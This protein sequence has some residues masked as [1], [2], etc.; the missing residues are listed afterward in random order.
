MDVC[1]TCCVCG[2][3]RPASGSNGSRR[4]WWQFCYW[5]SLRQSM[6]V[7]SF[8]QAAPTAINFCPSIEGQQATHIFYKAISSLVVASKSVQLEHAP[9]PPTTRTFTRSLR[10]SPAA[11]QIDFVHFG[12]IADN[13][14]TGENEPRTHLV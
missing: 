1:I 9:Q 11:K 13:N 10:R 8:F 12:E 2:W 7:L 5:K 14:M 3:V 6:E 4:R